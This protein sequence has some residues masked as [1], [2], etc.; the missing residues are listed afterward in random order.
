MGFIKRVVFLGEL[1]LLLM[2]GS[3]V[4]REEQG[5]EEYHQDTAEPLGSKAEQ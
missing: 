3:A 2:I 1:F 5:A 4:R